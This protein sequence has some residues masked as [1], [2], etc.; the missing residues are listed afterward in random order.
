[1][2]VLIIAILLLIS[3]ALVWFVLNQQSAAISKQGI[4]LAAGTPAASLLATRRGK[5]DNAVVIT[6][7][8]GSGKTSLWYH[9]RFPT[10]RSSSGDQNKKALPDTQTSM[11]INTAE[12]DV[13]EA[14][15]LLVDVPGHPKFKFDRDSHLALAKGVV[16]VVDSSTISQSLR[17]I[18]ESLYDVLANSHIQR[19]EC[20]VLLLCNKQ[21]E[22]SSLS[23]TR[24][25]AMLED[26]I[27][28]LRS[29]RQAALDSLRDTGS[30]LQPSKY[31]AGNDD[32]AAEEKANDFLGYDGKKFSF[33]DLQTP[34]QINE[35]SMFVGHDAGGLEQIERWIAD[36]I[37]S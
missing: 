15:A 10:F 23:N 4:A 11:A 7:P 3:G 20:P 22:P 26:E 9:L 32:D 1:M 17:P 8:S 14:N 13:H 28:R 29:S 31:L 34:V 25:K 27:D 5:V 19:K 24:I 6:G 33:E 35:S 2:L 21:D 36:T 12:T 18:A 16:F 30:D 37:H